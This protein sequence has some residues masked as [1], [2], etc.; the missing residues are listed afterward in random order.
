[1]PIVALLVD[2]TVGHRILSF[3]DRHSGYNQIFIVEKDRN[4]MAFRCLGLIKTFEWVIMSI[5]L[6]NAGATYR[7]TMNYLF[8]DM[9]GKF[10][11]VYIDD[12]IVKS[13]SFDNHLLNL[14]KKFRRMRKHQLKMNPLK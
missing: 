3:M 10:I 14:E 2:G 1:M 11:E 9:I 5:G 7:Q 6:K 4:K 12:I 13:Q 8:H